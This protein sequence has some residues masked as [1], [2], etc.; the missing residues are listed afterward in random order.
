MSLELNRDLANKFIL[1]N[2]ISKYEINKIAGDASFRSYYRVSSNLG[3]YI[4]MY[5]PPLYEKIDSFIL[6]DKFLCDNNFSAPQIFSID[7]DN[8]FILLE[9]FGDK[10][11]SKILIENKSKEFE[12]IIYIKACDCLINLH[13]SNISS[14]KIESY[15]IGM[16][17]REVMLFVDWYLPYI[18]NIKLSVEQIAIY[19]SL[20][21]QLFDDLSSDMVV[22]L[23][24]YHADNL[25]IIEDR[26]EYKAVGL[27]DFQDAV[28]GSK[29][30]DLVSLL[31]D[32]RR[33]VSQ[34]L[35]EI[36]INYYVDKSKI[37]KDIFL[38]DYAILSLQR[39]IKILGI[40]ARLA[41]R[42]GKVNYLNFIARVKN[43]IFKR[44]DINK[45]S[46]NSKFIAI[47]EFIE[48]LI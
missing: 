12:E 33:D 9:D 45:N 41:Y 32:A 10:T 19:K 48:K 43:H 25:M 20:W 2:N 11:Y 34:E 14:L 15:N 24:D 29:A 4:L 17:F 3:S 28:I 39:N 47:S 22:V 37:N 35:A 13:K 36:I 16:L 23:R 18:K 8:G 30:Y 44:N 46:A 31:E 38:R 27:L 5:A 1:S 6:I 7:K 21:F 42:D 40:F 26:L